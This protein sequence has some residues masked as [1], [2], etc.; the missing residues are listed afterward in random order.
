M[1]KYFKMYKRIS[2]VLETIMWIV[3]VLG[4]IATTIIGSVLGGQFAFIAMAVVT[5]LAV[6][7]MEIDSDYMDEYMEMERIEE[8]SKKF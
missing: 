6:C 5:S 1:S 7:I 8:E 3:I 4:S 2:N